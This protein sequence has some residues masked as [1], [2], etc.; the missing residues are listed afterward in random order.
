MNNRVNIKFLVVL[1][2]VFVL[3]ALGVGYVAYTKLTTSGEE[4][5]LRAEQAAEA[6]DYKLA[7]EAYGR[8]VAHDRTRQDWL[9]RW[10]YMLERYV[11]ETDVE[12]NKNY[13]L[14]YLGIYSQL[15]ALE[16]HNASAQHQLLELHYQR[17]IWQQQSPEAWPMSS[18]DI[19]VLVF[20]TGTVQRLHHVLN[21]V[22]QAL[23][24]AAGPFSPYSSSV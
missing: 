24:S 4:Y 6:G 3:L 17:L 14:F 22:R 12:F 2:S 13:S 7:S 16:L 11:P 5:T 10:L 20:S 8:A 9:K 19:A 1:C 18:C 23:H 15:A 21:P